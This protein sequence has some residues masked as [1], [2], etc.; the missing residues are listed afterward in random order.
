LLRL[1]IRVLFGSGSA[2]QKTRAYTRSKVCFADNWF[3]MRPDGSAR[4]EKGLSQIQSDRE[5]SR[6]A[7]AKGRAGLAVWILGRHPL[8]KH[9]TRHQI[10]DLLT[11]KVVTPEQVRAAGLQA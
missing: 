6:E 1:I 11:N 7:V 10:A 3:K 4:W 5:K 2:R 9:I 8:C